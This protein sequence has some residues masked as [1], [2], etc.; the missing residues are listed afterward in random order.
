MEDGRLDCSSPEFVELARRALKDGDRLRFRA[1]GRSMHPWIRDGD[2]ITV[3]KVVPA[4]LKPG[5][6][7]LYVRPGKTA[8]VHRIVSVLPEHDKKKFAIRGDAGLERPEYLDAEEVLG[9]VICLE[10]NGRIRKPCRFF[11][12]MIAPVHNFSK[13]VCRKLSTYIRQ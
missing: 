9:E 5:A 12:R 3:E 4:S 11:Y 8:V 1:R 7:V 10:R 13:R 6:I 2:I